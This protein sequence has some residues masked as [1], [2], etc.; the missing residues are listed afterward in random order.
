MAYVESHT[1]L[2]RHRKLREFARSLRLKPVYVMG[3]LHALWHAALEQ[4]EDGDLS[5][6]SDDLIAESSEYTGDAP[7][8]VSLLQEHRWLDDRLI[9]DWLDYAGAYLRGKYAKKNRDRLVQIWR[10]HGREY[11]LPPPNGSP[12]DIQ[13]ESNVL[14]IAPELTQ[15]AFPPKPPASGG[16]DRRRVRRGMTKSERKALDHAERVERLKAV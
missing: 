12:T 13:S 9:H 11:G 14:P 5:S 4:Q 1:V 8:Y 7:K 16:V 15:P 3:H 6:W 10:L 2:L